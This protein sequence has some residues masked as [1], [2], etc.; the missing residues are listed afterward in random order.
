MINQD[1][2]DFIDKLLVFDH[3]ERILPKEALEHPW[4]APVKA[5]WAM[6]ESGNITYPEGSAE[7]VTADI[8]KRRG[9]SN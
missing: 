4:L 6:V 8:V 1:V 2:L 7:R 9:S 5:M 3:A